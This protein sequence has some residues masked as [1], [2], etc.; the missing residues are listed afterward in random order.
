MSVGLKR[1]KIRRILTI[2]ISNNLCV[3][4]W[5]NKEDIPICRNKYI[6]RY[7][8]NL[9]RKITYL[10]IMKCILYLYICINT[11][12]Y[13]I[14]VYYIYIFLYLSIGFI[15][16]NWPNRT[17]NGIWLSKPEIHGAGNQ[18]GEIRS[19]SELHKH[20]QTGRNILG[21]WREIANKMLVGIS[22]LREG[23]NLF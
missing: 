18:E 13:V 7:N 21:K 11:H 1:I 5:M 15:V 4:L 10:Y 19:R 2:Y 8:T 14:Q 3:C 23:L 17:I 6:E 20:E 9:Q 12:T 16:M 22:K